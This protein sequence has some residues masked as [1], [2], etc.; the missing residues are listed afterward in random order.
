MKFMLS[1]AAIFA[2]ISISFS[3]FSG[4]IGGDSNEAPEVLL[5]PSVAEAQINHSV[6][7]SAFAKNFDNST[8]EFHW[9]FGDGNAGSGASIV[10]VFGA[11]GIFNISVEALDSNGTYAKAS[12]NFVVYSYSEFNGSMQ[13]GNRSYFFEI[14]NAS[15][16]IVFQVICQD[17]SKLNSTNLSFYDS[18]G[19]EMTPTMMVTPKQLGDGTYVRKIYIKNET[20]LP[21]GNWEFRVNSREAL[22]PIVKIAAY[23]TTYTAPPCCA[24]G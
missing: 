20:G 3:A 12:R 16:M 15:K 13:P 2:L 21:S 23:P 17:H 18:T 4:C 1:R 22:S 24:N 11:P 9:S 19:R 5:W 10:H 6:T 8:L 7:F 14:S